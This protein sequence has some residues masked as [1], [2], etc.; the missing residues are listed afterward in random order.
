MWGLEVS[1]NPIRDIPAMAFYGLERA[2]WELHLS[3]NLLSRIPAESVAPLKKLSVLN[4]AGKAFII[5]GLKHGRKK[6]CFSCVQSYY[7]VQCSGRS[8]IPILFPTTV[9]SK[10]PPFSP[11]SLLWQ[12]F[13]PGTERRRK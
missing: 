8:I 7:T 6:Y 9:F 2:L 13:S 11:P 4:L 12:K 3:G 1:L 10:P 5:S